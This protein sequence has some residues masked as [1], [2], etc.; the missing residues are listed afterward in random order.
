MSMRRIVVAAGALLAV[1][2]W[3]VGARAQDAPRAVVAAGTDA[4]RLHGAMEIGKDWSLHL[5][6]DLAYA[7]PG[8][9][10][11]GWQKVD[12]RRNPLPSDIVAQGQARWYRLHLHVP[13]GPGSKQVLLTGQ[14]GSFELYVNGRRT[15]P[16]M[17]PSFFWV[18]ERPMVYELPAEASGGDVVL[19]VRSHS[20]TKEF[21][22]MGDLTAALVGDPV[23]IQW[24][25]DAA[26]AR[27]LKKYV[28]ALAVYLLT[29]VLGLLLLVLYAKQRAHREYLWLGLALIFCGLVNGLVDAEI[30]SIIPPSI[31]AMFGDPSIY[32]WVVAQLE[33][34]FVFTGKRPGRAVRI[35]EGVL[36]AAPFFLDPA[37]WFALLPF[38]SFDVVENS[39][40]LPGLCLLGIMLI[41]WW[42]QGSREAGILVAPWLLSALGILMFN[43]QDFS[44]VF[45]LGW[46]VLP[47][48]QIGPIT[49]IYWDLCQ[50]LY[51][52]S[53]GAVLL[54]RFLQISREQA[55][56]AAEL[57]AARVVQQVLLPEP[58]AS[59][60]GFR[61]EAEYLPA[62]E[63]GGDFYQI[64]PTR[65]GG[66]VL[67]TG[68]VSGKGMP[69][70]MLVALLV[71]AIRTEAA[72]TSDPAVLLETLNRR[73]H[74]RMND[75][76]ATCAVLHISL[77]GA[78]LL[79][80]AANPAPY[81]NGEEV[82]LPGALPLGMLAEVVY[83]N[84]GFTLQPGDMLTFVS[85]GVVEAT[86][87]E[88]KELFGF[89]RM[90][91]ISQRPAEEV[92]ETARS[93]GQTDDITVV[94][95]TRLLEAIA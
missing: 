2:M 60:E 58:N 6:D 15:G 45:G 75:G 40:V 68:D 35:Y 34:A 72:H 11:S 95:V 24:A 93:F 79:A 9:D 32:F 25:R 1:A 31:N 38:G 62:Q 64:L 33:F 48:F 89:E 7:E 14:V 44:D 82:K 55:R 42:R 50:L 47:T 69:A 53:I 49:V 22:T 94:T 81:L 63:V 5:G 70:A 52:L 56:S 88:T 71:G 18:I 59:I 41:V 61:V 26:E 80:N 73:V 76:F 86:K 10:D 90:V 78:A 87:K 83:E 77:D 39:L 4:A 12:L 36:I 20:Y 51:L 28:F 54:S 37:Y 3:G 91:E 43:V 85:D 21:G 19:A 67:V 92:A 84:Y 57:E 17:R 46:S 8:Y 29:F 27:L 30:A 74:G 16:A 13:D 66:L 23:A 65:D